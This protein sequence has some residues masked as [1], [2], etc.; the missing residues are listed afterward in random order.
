MRATPEEVGSRDKSG[1]RKLPSLRFVSRRC[2]QRPNGTTILSPEQA[3]REWRPY[4]REHATLPFHII[5]SRGDLLGLALAVPV[6]VEQPRRVDLFDGIA[7]IVLIPLIRPS[8]CRS[9]GFIGARSGWRTQRSSRR[10][11]SARMTENTKV[12]VRGASA[13]GGP[14][15]AEQSMGE[16]STHKDF[17]WG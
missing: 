12:P 17:L 15:R 6:D 16:L 4:Q 14:E 11:V 8:K 5:R 2:C 7:P 13:S 10:R 3:L 9:G 1:E